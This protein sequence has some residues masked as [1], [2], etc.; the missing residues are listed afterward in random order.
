MI[1]ELLEQPLYMRRFN[2]VKRI[3][4][5][6]DGNPQAGRIYDKYGISPTIGIC[7]GGGSQPI[8]C[9]IYETD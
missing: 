6:Y 8:I 2:R 5:C 4:H 1:G 3:G 9:M 7:D